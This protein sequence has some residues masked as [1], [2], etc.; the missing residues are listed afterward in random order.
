MNFQVERDLEAARKKAE[1]IAD[2]EAHSLAS[3]IGRAFSEA[4][5]NISIEGL[6]SIGETIGDALAGGDI[7]DSFKK[8]GQMLGGAVQALGK[9]IIALSVAALAAKKAIKGIFANPLVGIAAGVTLVA[10]GAALKNLL[11]G[12]IKGF[13]TGG[14]V[15]GHGSGDTVPAMLNPW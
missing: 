3:N 10:V 9:Q 7:S 12:G 5:S 4:L 14:K 11:G 6:S 2:E 15:P 8:F 13:A 1:G